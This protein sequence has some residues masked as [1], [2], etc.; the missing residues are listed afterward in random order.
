[1]E[2]RELKF[3]QCIGLVFGVFVVV[4]SIVSLYTSITG[5]NSSVST[6]FARIP[7]GVPRLS[8]IE[9]IIWFCLTLI[10]MLLSGILFVLYL[11]R[12]LGFVV[13]TCVT[14]FA[15]KGDPSPPMSSTQ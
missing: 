3:W 5:H 4:S 10:V 12:M 8:L 11:P 7:I 14:K 6:F 2:L 1:M 9:P 13:S 15:L